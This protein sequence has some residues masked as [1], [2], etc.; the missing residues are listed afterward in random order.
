[1]GGRRP[2]EKPEEET[3]EETEEEEEEARLGKKDV[4]MVEEAVHDR[5]P[6]R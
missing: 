5:A 1:M 4:G 6:R 2:P 3:E